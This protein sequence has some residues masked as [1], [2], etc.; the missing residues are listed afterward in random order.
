MLL[1]I[2]I[3]SNTTDKYTRKPCIDGQARKHMTAIGDC[4]VGSS[5]SCVTK[6][7]VSLKSEVGR[8]SGT[9]P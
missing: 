9:A 8:Q 4:F 6:S 5:V 3:F 1:K 2:K 7:R